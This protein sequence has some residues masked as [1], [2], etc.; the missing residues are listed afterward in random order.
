MT[1]DR[2]E[3]ISNL[4]SEYHARFPEDAIVVLAAEQDEGAA[5]STITMVGNISPKDMHEMISA[6]A[7]EAEVPTPQTV[8][9]AVPSFTKH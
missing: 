5:E 7:A 2:Y 3:L 9:H 4:L 6:T 1:N 8:H